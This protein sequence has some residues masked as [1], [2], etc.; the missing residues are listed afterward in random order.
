MG[1]S[2]KRGRD[3]YCFTFYSS[4]TAG[5]GLESLAREGIDSDVLRNEIKEN[6]NLILEF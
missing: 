6:E 5:R 4:A 1:N 2:E 3:M